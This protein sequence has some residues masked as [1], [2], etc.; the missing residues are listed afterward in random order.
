M[1]NKKRYHLIGDQGVSMRGLAKYLK[2]LGHTVTGS[3]LKTGGHKPEN[4]ASDIDVVVRTSAVN[5][6]SEGWVEV[7]AAKKK[8]I[9]VIKRSE[10]IAEL[11][12]GKKLIAVS[13]MH[14]KTTVTA[15]AGLVLEAA[16]FDP[17]VLI[18]DEVKEFNDD[19]IRIGQSDWFVLEACEYD[20][21]FLDF[22]PKI[23]ILTNIEEEHLDTYPGG[24]AEIK[25]AF[26]EY[27]NH[28]PD[29]GLIIACSDDAN[30]K[31]VLSRIKTKAK[32]IYYGFKSEKYNKLGFDLSIPGQHNILNALSVIALS[33]YVGIDRKLAEKTLAGFKGAH[34][35]FELRGSFKGADLIDDYGHHPTEIESTIDA[36]SERYPDK[37]KIVVFW[38]HQYKRILPLL[39]QFAQAFRK[40]DQVI[41]LPIF[42]VPGRDEI[43]NVKSEDLVAKIEE[44]GVQAQSCETLDQAAQI[45]TGKLDEK[46]VLLTIGIPPVYQVIDKILGA[47]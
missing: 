29:D 17:T 47:K 32:T 23:L 12:K 43:L 24:L 38:P 37:R 44:S 7:E 1:I 40:A 41:V 30:I 11:T 18:G 4:I 15:M 21:S 10:L 28:I 45:L 35:R 34:R 25:E 31:D 27:I 36:L 19:V 46:S 14:G 2:Y 13:G 39:N 42:F 20:R 8:G 3:D 5:P 26:I 9:E 33:D 22:S 6:G 16:N